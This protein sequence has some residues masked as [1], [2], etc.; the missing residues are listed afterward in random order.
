MAINN[1]DEK[2]EEFD[3]DE[4]EDEA[5]SFCDLP[6][7]LICKEDNSGKEENPQVVGTGEDFDFGSWN[8]SLLAESDMCAADEVFF[9]GQILPL[10]LSVSSDSGLA[11][12]RND[13][14]KSSRCVSRSESMDRGSWGGFTSVSSRS[15]SSRSHNSSISST[16]TATTHRS[17]VRNHFHAHP[18]P[19][20]QIKIFNTRQGNIGSRGHKSTM[21]DLFRP[22]LVR[23]PEIELQD[24]K[25]R[26]TNKGFDSRNSS[27]SS[28]FNSTAN[29]TAKSNHGFNAEKRRSHRFSIKK[30]EFLSGC[31]CSISAVD[32][33]PSRIVVIKTS[34]N[35]GDSN[36][37]ER[38]SQKQRQHVKKKNMHRT[39][40][41]LKELSHAAA[42]D[43]A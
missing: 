3:S 18:S 22:G 27:R 41:W 42:P 12:Y 39:F 40:E 26:S 37:N 32:P 34:S 19:K 16:S 43:E 20:P 8:R 1:D 13:S 14:R 7:D 6:N 29:N 21:W 5:L 24:L 2:W 28:S 31:K 4:E 36:P 11:G 25:V 38:P 35:G 9:Q 17:R 15:S 10:R 23:T 33:V 30:R